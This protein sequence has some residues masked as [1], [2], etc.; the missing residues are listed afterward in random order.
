MKEQDV[1]DAVNLMQTTTTCLQKVVC[2]TK[3]R[4]F[5]LYSLSFSIGFKFSINFIH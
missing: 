4:F 1:V 5:F 3:I 2:F